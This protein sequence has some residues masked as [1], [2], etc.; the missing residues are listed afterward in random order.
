M[1]VVGDVDHG[2]ADRVV[3]PPQLDAHVGPQRRVEVRQGLVEE[4]DR[5][6]AHE[7]PGQ[8]DPL[9]LTAG[10]LRR[11]VARAARRSPTSSADSQR[12][13][14]G[15][16]RLGHLAD[17][18]AEADVL[19][20]VEVGEQG[21]ALEHHRHV[22][23]RGRTVGHVGA[24]DQHPAGADPLEAGR[25]PQRGRLA[26]AGRTE[27]ADRLAVADVEVERRE[28]GDVAVALG[29]RR[30]TSAAPRVAHSARANRS[31]VASSSRR[32]HLGGR[33]ASASRASPGSRRPRPRSRATSRSSAAA[34]MAGIVSRN[35]ADEAG[36]L[37]GSRKA[38]DSATDRSDG[39]V[40]PVRAMTGAPSGAEGELEE[41]RRPRRGA[42]SPSVR[43]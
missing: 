41:R 36:A 2:R 15:C 4:Q 40:R 29:R 11:V 22:A 14:G 16:S 26:R 9:A 32:G 8:R 12:R 43:Q 1:L 33:R 19:G 28:R 38:S 20:D 18:Q 39:T 10:E 42:R 7:R 37:A 30:R 13:A 23:L 17:G 6:L 25:Q 21:V 35:T 3:E 5:R 31:R 27:H 34:R 24:V